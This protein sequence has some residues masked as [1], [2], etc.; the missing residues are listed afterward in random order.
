MAAVTA[1]G[2]SPT[3]TKVVSSG[4]SLLVPVNTS[5][6]LLQTTSVSIT[7]SGTTMLFLG[8]VSST[9]DPFFQVDISVDGVSI[10]ND[11]SGQQIIARTSLATGAHT[12]TF[13]GYALNQDIT[14]NKFGLTIIDLGL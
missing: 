9:N 2:S 4:A 7:G 3:T 5:A 14:A 6:S 11:Q 10:Y 1:T 12:V 13:T 8:R